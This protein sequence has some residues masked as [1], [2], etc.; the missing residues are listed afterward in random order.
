MFSPQ[1]NY[2]DRSTAAGLRMNLTSRVAMYWVYVLWLIVL[3]TYP[4]SSNLEI[5][6]VLI[7]VN[8]SL[9]RLFHH[10]FSAIFHELDF[11]AVVK[12]FTI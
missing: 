9:H 11:I 4:L 8:V 12:R 7:F 2:A 6:F 3:L 10:S 5:V 1:A